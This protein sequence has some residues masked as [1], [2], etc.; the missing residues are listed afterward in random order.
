MNYFAHIIFLSLLFITPPLNGQHHEYDPHQ[1]TVDDFTHA[2]MNDGTEFQREG[3]SY[4]VK[5]SAYAKG[6][7]IRKDNS[8]LKHG[9]FFALYKGKITSITSYAYG[10]KEGYYKAFHANGKLSFKYRYKNGLKHGR[11]Y[12]YAKN[13]ALMEEKSYHNGVMNGQKITYHDNGEKA[14][15][16][17]YVDGKLHGDKYVYNENGELIAKSQYEMGQ[18]LGRTQ[19]AYN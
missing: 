19:Y 7:Y 6:L 3:Q 1:L 17:T 13:G 14:F 16:S 5:N 8:W 11:W 2:E 4:K 12:Q 9:L 10:K 18:K 15:A